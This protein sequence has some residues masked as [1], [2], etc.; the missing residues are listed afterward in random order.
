MFVAHVD[1]G[2]G[3]ALGREPAS[4][5]RIDP[6]VAGRAQAPHPLSA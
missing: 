4:G 3:A 2:L 5:H 1:H 6:C